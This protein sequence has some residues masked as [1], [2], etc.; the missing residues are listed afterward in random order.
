[1]NM[2]VLPGK[3]FNYKVEF[4]TGDD[5]ASPSVAA[6]SV[7]DKDGVVV[8]S[9]P[10]TLVSGA[11][12]AWISIPGVN[13]T[14]DSGEKFHHL[15]LEVT[16][17]TDGMVFVQYVT[18]FVVPDLFLGYTQGTVRSLIGLS[19]AE[20]DDEEIDFYRSYI[21]LTTGELGDAFYSALTGSDVS[22][23]FAARQLIFFNTIHILLP[24]IRFNVLK[25][26]Q[27]ET[28]KMER[29][30]NAGSIEKLENFIHDRMTYYTALIS[31][32]TAISPVFLILS[33]PTD[34]I[35]GA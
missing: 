23:Q 31:T 4:T 21:D 25:S 10:I 6:Y 11:E 30:S 34:P 26:L 1:M 32:T 22:L 14:L 16:H 15:R 35:T 13:H 8:A 3:P 28:S 2:Y 9:T 29:M 33:S 18:Y 17:T 20:M 5:P 27:S 24:Q 7:T 19:K 12:S